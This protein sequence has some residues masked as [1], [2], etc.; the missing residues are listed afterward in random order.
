MKSIYNETVELQDLFPDIDCPTVGNMEFTTAV[1]HVLGEQGY[2]AMS[3]Q[4]IS[5]INFKRIGD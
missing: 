1:R 4:V 3:D 2:I 5:L